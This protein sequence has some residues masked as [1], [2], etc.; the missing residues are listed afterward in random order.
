MRSC[1]PATAHTFRSGPARYCHRPLMR[2][3]SPF[4]SAC[5][6]AKC[7]CV[8]VAGI[9]TD[10][11]NELSARDLAVELPPRHAPVGFED[12]PS[13]RFRD[14]DRLAI[15]PAECHIVGGTAAT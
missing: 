6:K 2:T 15:R 3:W 9:E 14:V 12:R 1:V 4:L 11:A 10:S 13:R 7:K 5:W 8:T